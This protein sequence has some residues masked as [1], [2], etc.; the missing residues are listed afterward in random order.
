QRFPLACR[1]KTLVV[2][3]LAVLAG[4]PTTK[5]TAWNGS[6]L[7]VGSVKAAFA[8]ATGFGK[9]PLARVAISSDITTAMTLE[10]EFS[11]TAKADLEDLVLLVQYSAK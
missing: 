2:S 3:E 9:Y 6:T 11:S 7:G 4:V 8:E 5:R 10:L 1:G